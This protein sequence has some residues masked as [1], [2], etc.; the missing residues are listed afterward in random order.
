MINEWGEIPLTQLYEFRS[1]LSKPRS[2]FGYG[3]GFLSFK[4]VFYNTFVPDILKEKVNSSVKEKK[5]CSIKKGDVF[6]TRTSETLEELGMSCVA[7]EDYKFA[8]FNGFCKR[9][10]PKA[11]DKIVP[12]YAGYY[13]RSP[14]FRRQ[15]IALS[16]LSTRASLNNE[17]LG[18]LS[19]VLPDFSEQ[20]AIGYILKMFDD[21]IELNRGKNKS[22]EALAQVIF[23]SWFVDFNPVYA[24]MN[25]RQPFG[26]DE[27]TTALFPDKLVWN[28]ELEKEIPEGWKMTTIGDHAIVT[29]GK[30]PNKRE[31]T[32]SDEFPIPLYG[33]AGPM[34]YADISLYE[35]PIII[36][37]R[38]G[39]LGIVH[40]VTFSVWPSDNTLVIIP[41]L[42]Y[43]PL[44]FH[45]I[46]RENLVILNRGSTQPL[47]TQSDLKTI[48][49]T[50]PDE[51][52]LLKFNEIVDGIFEL[53]DLINNETS[54]LSSIRDTLLPKLMSGELDG[55]H[56][57]KKMEA[58]YG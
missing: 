40:R 38:V 58:K 42:N 44:L 54:T 41:K 1:G 19:I 48:K 37:G 4:D 43:L 20:K 6:L 23:K 16:S 14:H 18:Q 22:L 2:E 33:G 32:C 26:M 46:C 29:S 55:R 31:A 34:A 45:Y 11:D 56:I 12:E 35:E 24:K 50:E 53:I 9:L 47:L 28:D 51:N 13:F 10:R 15:V 25:G 49:M 21:K 5:A 7:L 8:T 17:M 27:E 39:T 30:R 57:I 36:T 52:V 3:H